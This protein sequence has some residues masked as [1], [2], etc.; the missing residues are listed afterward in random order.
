MVAFAANNPV[1]ADKGMGFKGVGQ[2]GGGLVMTTVGFQIEAYYGLDDA[3]DSE[4][5]FANL[6]WLVASTLNSYGKLL[7][8][9]VT[10][11]PCQIVKCTYAMLA[12]KYL[13]HYA[14]LALSIQGR[15]Q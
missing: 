3:N 2:P 9:V 1:I 11:G 8:D 13:T 6:A 7:D 12:N 15:T 10:Q 14:Q 4:E 5:A